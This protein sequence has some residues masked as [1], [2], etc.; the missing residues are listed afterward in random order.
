MVSIRLYY[1][2]THLCTIPGHVGYFTTYFNKGHVRAESLLALRASALAKF[3]EVDTV[4]VSE[5]SE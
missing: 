3:G 2:I 5:N 4:P 1:K